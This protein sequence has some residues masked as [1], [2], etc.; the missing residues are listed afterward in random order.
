MET[1]RFLELD[2]LRL[3]ND[4]LEVLVTQSVG[5]RVISLRL[6]GGQNLLAELPEAKLDCPGAG[7]FSMGRASPMAR[8][9]SSPP[10]VFAR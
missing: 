9:G 5:P 3:A 2:C 4:L 10:N 8:P 7:T 6:P 1:T